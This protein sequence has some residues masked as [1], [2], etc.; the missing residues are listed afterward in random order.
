MTGRERLGPIEKLAL[1]DAESVGEDGVAVHGVGRRGL[2]TMKTERAVSTNI[3]LASFLIHAT[4]KECVKL[5]E[6]KD[7]QCRGAGKDNN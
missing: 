5:K 3:C 4:G 1:A 2:C 7:L 6:K